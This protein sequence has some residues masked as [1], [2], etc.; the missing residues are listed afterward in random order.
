MKKQKIKE[1]KKII[2]NPRFMV[3]GLIAVIVVIGL[4][5]T[6]F[7]KYSPIMNFKYE[8][9]AVS[10]KE[11]TEKLTGEEETEGEDIELTK[12]E[13][14][15][16]IFKK[17]SK[18]F[19]GNK[20][21]TEINLNY[22]IYINGNS[23]IY[24]LSEESVLISKDFERIAG[25][26]NLSIAEGKVYDGNSLERTDGKEYIFVETAD[27][28]YINLQEIK[29][30][31]TANEYIIPSNSI[32]GFTEKE[33]RYYSV[34]NN[35][36]VFNQIKD[37]DENTRVEI[38][39]NSYT[40]EEIL[41]KLG[42][43][44][45]QEGNT[46][47]KE[48]TEENIIKEDTTSKETTEQKE[49]VE[50]EKEETSEDQINEGEVYIKPEVSV[51]EF[52]AE[53]YT[54]KSVLHIQ[55]PAGKI[56]EA[57]TFEIY[58]NGKIYL[59]RTYTSSGNITVT[60]LEP[61]TEYEIKGKYVYVNEEEKK[62]ENTFYTGK[63]ETKGYD[64]LGTIK[65]EKE[66]GEIYSDRIQIKNL[67]ITS[68]LQSEVIRGINKIEIVAQGIK[69]T[70]KN[71]E[72]NQLLQGKEVT[73]ESSEGLKA[74]SKI[75]YEIKI[76]DLLGKEL[77]VENSKG[78][79]RTAKE[80]PEVKVSIKEQNIV[81]VTLNIK[82]TNK[83]K[84][85]IE[86][87]K[88]IITQPNGNKVKEEKLAENET[89]IVLDDLDSNQYYEIKV[90]AD[91]DLEDEKGIQKEQEI[92]KLV[93]ATS[94]LSTLGSV[95]MKVEGKDITT[96]KATIEYEI[97]EERTDKRLIQ[98]LE[99]IKIEIINKNSQVVERTKEIRGEELEKL[100]TGEKGTEKYEELKSNTNY[101]IR[102][103]SKVKTGQ[104]EE[105][106]QVTYTYNQFTTLRTAAK[107]E[108]QNQ[109]VT[110]EM[111][112]LDVRIEDPDKSVLNN[113]VRMELRDENNNL[114]DLE[115]IETNQEYKRKTYDKLEEEKKYKLSFYADE[116]NEGET[117]ATYKVNYLIKEIEI[118]T[119]PG[120][121]GNIGLKS[122]LRMTTG[123]N[124]VDVESK[125][126]WYSPMFES[127]S[128]Y[129]KTYDKNNNV[130]KLS[131]GKSINN[132]QIYTYDLRDYIGQE[133]T[134]SF[135]IKADEEIKK[136]K[137]PKE[138]INILFLGANP[139]IIL[140]DGSE[141]SKLKL[142]KEAREI[143]EAITKSLNRDS[144]NLE[145]RWAV[146]TS[147][148][149]QAINEVN[150]TIIHFS[151]HGTEDGHLVLQDNN[152]NPK[153]VDI[154]S[155]VK[156]IDASTDN[157]RLIVF[158]NCFSS[159]FAECVVDSVEATIGMNNSI[160][161]EAAIIFSSQ[162][163]SAI[164]FGNSLEK[165][166]NQAKARLLLEGIKE[167]RTPELFVNENFNSSD[168]YIVKND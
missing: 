93:F 80:K 16:R 24:N 94:P 159:L 154:D 11:I 41:T 65:I 143:K 7:L 158:N 20:E 39:E 98:I 70:L 87:Y 101:E 106:I 84:A 119:E 105:G 100:K 78:E 54:A 77:K 89:T 66:N 146:R 72:V 82:L 109:F 26:P 4:I 120:I 121:S 117:D 14:Q 63:I 110:G 81:S 164:G 6:I 85:K 91:Y 112:D 21:K 142:D 38:V 83:N 114:I 47:Q 90:Y 165:S 123:K 122:M 27:K 118:I 152:D 29:I 19:V 134:I 62:V 155:I 75:E 17:L 36:L 28:I 44:G 129:E 40:Y 144:I 46:E 157:L 79:T 15:G 59:R 25:Y 124:L 108:I 115:E 34:N 132:I 113:K 99:E 2:K 58:K 128:F 52:T 76:Y 126:K 140:K 18:Y 71:N 156:M 67:K 61:G 5:Y 131:P 148:L 125:V 92:G 116:Y 30:E 147:D 8:G 50:E 137:Q 68:D 31:T 33:V 96:D 32:I 138:K 97:D 167:D 37:V 145:T 141:Q 95:E 161:D 150:P 51:E 88:Y 69:T 35:V 43:I 168:I 166:F 56:I 107:V 103:T 133:V 3:I 163:Y 139:D 13:E 149:F 135:K 9:Y 162:L 60:G 74:D 86:N 151:G 55:D 12:I 57:P 10:G 127:W 160:S 22:P 153:F 73:V 45:K 111:I 102:I 48:E 136:L 1:E 42:I 53:V 64:S 49:Q 104:N 23:S 130:L